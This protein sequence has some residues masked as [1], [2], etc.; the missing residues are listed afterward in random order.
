[1]SR[2]LF[3]IVYP[4]CMKNGDEEIVLTGVPNVSDCAAGS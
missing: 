4:I 2:V 1:M 3:S